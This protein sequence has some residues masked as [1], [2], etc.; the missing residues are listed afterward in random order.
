MCRT[1]SSADGF[2]LLGDVYICENFHPNMPPMP[3]RYKR[4]RRSPT[5]VYRRQL[6]TVPSNSNNGRQNDTVVASPS[7]TPAALRDGVP[8]PAAALPSAAATAALHGSSILRGSCGE[9][10]H[11]THIAPRDD[12][13]VTRVAGVHNV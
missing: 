6:L 3:R 8:E 4:H 2:L 1:I 12:S 10:K 7:G 11:T 9:R 13:A 5:L